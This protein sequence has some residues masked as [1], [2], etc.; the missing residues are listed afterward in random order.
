MRRPSIPNL[1]HSLMAVALAVM[2]LTGCEEAVAPVLDSGRP[3]TLYGYLNPGADHQAIRVFPIEEILAP[4]SPEPLDA[5]VRVTGPGLSE[6]LRDSVIVYGDGS[7]GHVFQ[8]DF[9]PEHGMTY[10]IRAEEPEGRFS[11]VQVRTPAKAQLSIG[12]AGGVLG[13]VLMPV[14]FAGAEQVLSPSV[15]YTF[16]STRA[17]FTWT[18]P[19]VYGDRVVRAGDRWSVTV[20]LSRD[21]GV[22]Y[23]VTGLQPGTDPIIL[24]DLLVEAFIT[25]SEWTPPGGTYDPELLVQPGTFS[26][27]ENGF[28]FVGGGYFESAT[29]LPPAHILQLAGFANQ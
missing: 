23:S 3:F 20:D 16:E 6:V 28:G 22:L 27:V 1:M 19:V 17:P 7:V 2:V 10:E 24:T 8:A 15:L 9:R 11:T 29:T 14:E 21:I 4:N 5:L 12:D 25:T 18:I 13:N 26:N